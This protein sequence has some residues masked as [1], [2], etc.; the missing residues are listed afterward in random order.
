[1]PLKDFYSIAC[2]QFCQSKFFLL[3]AAIWFDEQ[4]EGITNE[5]FE[6]VFFI[7][8]WLFFQTF[9]FFILLMDY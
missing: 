4:F 3:M 2:L 9:N 8:L 5:Y 1:M 6:K 7:G